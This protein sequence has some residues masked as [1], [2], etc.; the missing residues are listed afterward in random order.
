[1]A[2]K[3]DKVDAGHRF[4]TVDPDVPVVM[5]RTV[6]W[7]LRVI[8]PEALGSCFGIVVLEPVVQTTGIARN[9]L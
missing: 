7:Y 9:R 2:F 8:V 6:S 5:A 4:L 1:M 3:I